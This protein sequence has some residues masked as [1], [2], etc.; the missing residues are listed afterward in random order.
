MQIRSVCLEP[1]VRI[2]RWVR[3]QCTRDAAKI[4]ALVTFGIAICK[5]HARKDPAAG[6]ILFKDRGS[7]VN[8][9]PNADNSF[10]RAGQFRMALKSHW[11][12][13]GH[14]RITS[15]LG[16]GTTV[17][18]FLPDGSGAD[19]ASI[20]SAPSQHGS[21]MGEGEVVL[22]VED[23]SAVRLLIVDVLKELRYRTLEAEDGKHALPIIESAQRI[24]AVVS[25]VGLPGINGRHLAEVA[26]ARRPGLRVL[27]LTGYAATASSRADFLG[28]GMDMMTKPFSMDDLARI[29]REMLAKD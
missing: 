1:W 6:S 12:T 13:G 19:K 15:Q 4:R 2:A 23:D 8:F 5:S 7:L 20:G 24:D 27:F 22:V 10:E 9:R 11:S 3:F 29:V 21:L 25:D 16:T 26:L 28:P 18:L 14:A 17:T